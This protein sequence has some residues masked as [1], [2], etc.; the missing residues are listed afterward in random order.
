MSRQLP[1][2]QSC[3][4]RDAAEAPG[5]TKNPTG[6]MF[7]NFITPALSF[8]A[9]LRG[10]PEQNKINSLRHEEVPDVNKNEG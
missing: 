3:E 6:R 7:S 10:T 8:V 9:A 1:W 4:R 5:R 2:L